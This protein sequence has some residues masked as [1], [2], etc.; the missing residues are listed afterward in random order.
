MAVIVDRISNGK[1]PS[2][3]L[4]SDLMFNKDNT[5]RSTNV[6]TD[7]WTTPLH[8]IPYINKHFEGRLVPLNKVHPNIPAPNEFRP[9]IVLSPI[10]KLLEGRFLSKASS[11]LV[12]RLHRGQTGF[13]PGCGIYVNILRAF[14]RIKLRTQ[15]KK[16]VYGLFI[17]FKSAYNTIL[18]E[19]LFGLLRNIYTEDETNF[20]KEMY[21]RLK[22]KAGRHSFRPNVG[23][24]QGSTL[25]PAFFN[26]YIN[27]LL[28]D[29]EEAGVSEEDILAYADD[30]LIF[31]ED[32]E[33]LKK[34]IRLIN[35]WCA[36]SNVKLNASKSAIV[37]LYIEGTIPS[38]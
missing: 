18:P 2:F 32:K 33:Q 9:I 26:I 10:F 24:P 1:A 8:Q 27:K 3:D 11:N 31:C 16:K 15:N 38:I 22:I 37:E 29:I 28:S 14:D 36:G 12:N 6:F 25:A 4:V 23:V 13:V 21:S 30:L 5:P 34:I 17:D 19:R 35:N 7:L 20:I